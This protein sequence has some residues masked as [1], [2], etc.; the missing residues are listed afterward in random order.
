MGNTDTLPVGDLLDLTGKSVL[1]TGASGN[2]GAGIA[3]RL[4]EAGASVIVHAHRNEQAARE[5]A[6]AIGGQA[7]Q[8]DLADAAAVT[9][10]FETIQPQLVVNNAAAQPVQALV[11]MSFD[12]WRSVMAANLDGAFLVTRL[13]AEQWR[14]S[15]ND[16]AMVNIASIEGSDPATGHS[17]YATSKAGLLMLT[18]AA[19]LEFGRDGIRVNAVSPGPV[20]TAMG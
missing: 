1:V 5:L 7:V 10:L 20:E 9:R 6:G 18:R 16:G 4:S 14:A 8:A 17:H 2:I 11:D 12:D 19:A 3:R 15:G 13:A